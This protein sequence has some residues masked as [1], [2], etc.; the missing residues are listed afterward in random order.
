MAAL[1]FVPWRSLCGTDT[2]SVNEV[3]ARVDDGVLTAAVDTLG[4]GLDELSA[5]FYKKKQTN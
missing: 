3:H 1:H 2:R 5:D 4:V